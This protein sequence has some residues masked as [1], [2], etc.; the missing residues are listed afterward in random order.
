MHGTKELEEI[1]KEIEILQDID[2]DL[3]LARI[4]QLKKRYTEIVTE[5]VPL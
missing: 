1:Q 4:E 5:N 2:T 3:A